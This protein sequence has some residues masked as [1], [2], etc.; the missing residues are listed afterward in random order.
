MRDDRLREQ[1]SEV[2]ITLATEARARDYVRDLLQVQDKVREELEQRYRE[3]AEQKSALQQ[4]AEALRVQL[5]SSMQQEKVPDATLTQRA[6]MRDLES[7]A[8]KFDHV[9]KRLQRQLEQE[10]RQSTF[11]HE[12][13]PTV[14]LTLR[15]AEARQQILV[16]EEAL[17]NKERAEFQA[18]LRNY[19]EQSLQAE[20]K[21]QQLRPVEQRLEALYTKLAELQ[22]VQVEVLR[23]R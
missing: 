12:Q 13:L 10:F 4:E 16:E 1:L 17:L 19:A 7:A 23:S 3:V 5:Q 9:L 21:R 6:R 11:L 20:R 2:R 8:A 22:P 15:R 14:E 18:R